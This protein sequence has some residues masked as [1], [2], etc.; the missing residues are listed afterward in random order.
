MKAVLLVTL[1]GLGIGSL[2][3][4]AAP[5][6][7]N[8]AGPDSIASERRIW[9]AGQKFQP[10]PAFLPSQPSLRSRPRYH[11]QIIRPRASQERSRLTPAELSLMHPIID[12][13]T[14]SVHV[15]NDVLQPGKDYTY[16]P[17]TN[18]IRI[19]NPQALRSTESIQIMYDTGSLGHTH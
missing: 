7:S 13:K 18:R 17:S 8:A 5:S 1:F 12:E 15:G 4:A 16:S 9:L 6:C 3:V 2:P 10:R 11:T 19:L 14:L